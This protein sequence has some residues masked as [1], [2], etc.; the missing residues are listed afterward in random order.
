MLKESDTGNASSRSSTSKAQHKSTIHRCADEE[1]RK[2]KNWFSNKEF[3]TLM[4][5]DTPLL[6]KAVDCIEKLLLHHLAATDDYTIFLANHRLM[7][8]SI[9]ADIEMN[10]SDLFYAIRQHHEFLNA[11]VVVFLYGETRLLTNQDGHWLVFAVDFSCDRVFVYDSCNR[12]KG[13]AEAFEKL[14]KAFTKPQLCYLA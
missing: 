12:F 6:N 5:E 8:D 14:K 2:S 10:K 9:D 13:V 1:I 3:N 4:K 11:R 7:T